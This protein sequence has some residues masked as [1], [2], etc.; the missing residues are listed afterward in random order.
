V[1]L[2]LCRAAA[3]LGLPV[4]DQNDAASSLDRGSSGWRRMS[5]SGTAVRGRGG[6]SSQFRSNRD[7]LLHGLTGRRPIKT[8]I[9]RSTSLVRWI[10]PAVSKLT[11]NV[12]VSAC[13]VLQPGF[14]WFRRTGKHKT[15]NS[16]HVQLIGYLDLRPI[17]TW[18]IFVRDNKISTI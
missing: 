5:M 11:G 16:N 14:C 8:M 18:V 6:E 3:L 17:Y 13:P 7:G 9:G 1:A 2:S 12:A 4:A 10:R 15:S